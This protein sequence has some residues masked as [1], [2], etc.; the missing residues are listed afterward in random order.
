MRRTLHP[1][2]NLSQSVSERDPKTEWCHERVRVIRTQNG[3]QSFRATPIIYGRERN[4][5]LFSDRLDVAGYGE[6]SL[7]FRFLSKYLTDCG[8]KPPRGC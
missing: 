7:R 6:C 5:L 4:S 8:R 1:F 2:V 3:L